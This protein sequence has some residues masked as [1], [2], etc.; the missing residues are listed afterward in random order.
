ML[1]NS[2]FSSCY[3]DIK[4]AQFLVLIQKNHTNYK[5]NDV[6]YLNSSCYL[7]PDNWFRLNQHLLYIYVYIYPLRSIFMSLE[8]KY[9]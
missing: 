5:N 4:D 2:A 6:K 7:I 3:P 8:F 9:N 1:R